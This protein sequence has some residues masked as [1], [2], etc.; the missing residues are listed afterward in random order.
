MSFIDKFK[1]P[2]TNG[3]EW[4]N[5]VGKTELQRLGCCGKEIIAKQKKQYKTRISKLI[6]SKEL[7]Q[8][9]GNWLISVEQTGF[10]NSICIKEKNHKGRCSNVPYLPKEYKFGKTP[11]DGRDPLKVSI[12]GMIAKI[13]DPI[14]NPG[15]NPC[16]L[17]NR[18][19]SR[20]NL[21]MLDKDTEKRLRQF[22]KN[23]RKEKYYV[24]LGIRLSMGATKYMIATAVID[25]YTM[26]Y[27]TKGVQDVFNGVPEN[28][29]KILNQRWEELKT[30]KLKEDQLVISDRN[31]IME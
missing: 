4:D 15:G 10:Q 20:N 11:K 13:K 14:N 31:K 8:D 12:N 29:K 18:G 5:V 22:A 3:I 2:Y 6:E 21:T 30:Q 27:F 17:Q 24:N 7:T 28:F 1:I 9:E 16:P 26:I 25:M 19:G 23:K